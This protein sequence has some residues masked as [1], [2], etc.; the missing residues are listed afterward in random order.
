MKRTILK[1]AEIMLFVDGTTIALAT[2][3]SLEVTTQTQDVRTKDSAYGPDKEF[4][5]CDWNLSSESLVG[6]NEDSGQQI[7]ADQLLALQLDGTPVEVVI[8]RVSRTSASIPAE[9]W[10]ESSAAP[11]DVVLGTYRGQALIMSSSVNAPAEGNATFSVKLEGRGR[12]EKLSA[13][14]TE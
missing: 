1:G 4:D 8:G 12:L 9:G 7:F 5:F 11:R 6:E 3:C 13:A 10:E 14:A 2:S